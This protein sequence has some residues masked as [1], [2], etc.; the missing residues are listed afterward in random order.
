MSPAGTSEKAPPVFS[1]TLV[2][3]MYGGK[4]PYFR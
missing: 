3:G 2:T 1:Y 4:K